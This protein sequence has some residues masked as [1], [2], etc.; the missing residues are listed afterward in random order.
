MTERTRSQGCVTDDP[1][2][3]RAVLLERAMQRVERDPEGC[4]LWTGIVHRNGYGQFS[5]APK[6]LAL[7]HRAMYELLV[8]EIP[9]GYQ[10]DHLC[11]VTRCVNPAHLEAVTP[12]EN[13][14]RSRATECR[15]G[16]AYT[17]EN[18]LWQDRGPLGKSKKCRTC[19]REYSRARRE[20]NRQAQSA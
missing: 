4:W 11:R 6:R 3:R 9:L 19:S 20:K 14:R 18:T 1:P 15:H 10:I 12:Q 16:H 5:V 8:G 2:A 17:P 13:L 7:A